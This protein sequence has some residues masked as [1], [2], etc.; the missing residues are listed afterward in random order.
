MEKKVLITGATGST[1]RNAVNR[2]LDLGISVRAMVHRIDRRSD[3]L[4]KRGVQ[5][6]QG[7][8]SVFDDVSNALEGIS[9][10]YYVYPI[11][12]GGII[13]STAFFAQAAL[14]QNVCH[15]LNMSQIS[16]RRISKSHA[17]QNH[18]VAER[19]FDRSGVPVTHIRP[20]FFAEWTTYFAGE[21]RENDRLTLPFGN[22]KYAPVTAEDQG[23]VI[24]AILAN[25]SAHAGKTYPLFGPVE[26]TQYDVAEILSEVLGRKITYASM[27]IPE[28]AEYLKDKRSDYHIQH[29]TAV[30][31]D[32]RDGLFSGTN[33][34]IEEI[35][36]KIPTGMLEFITSRKEIFQ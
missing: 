31:Q 36:G 3:E 12:I 9:A 21:I 25:P 14:E 17:A 32:C 33:D 6:V 34:F 1:G 8:I 35:T 30:A 19:I 28:F 22:A 10:A 18:W 15:I 2:L 4:E 7:D 27:E 23:N 20:T 16:A 5:V 24:A 29:I 13:E 26:L 11:T